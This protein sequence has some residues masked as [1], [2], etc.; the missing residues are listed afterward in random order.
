MKTWT[1]EMV[2]LLG[3]ESDTALAH[4]SDMSCMTVARR[5]HS[6]AIKPYDPKQGGFQRETLCRWS[7]ESLALLGHETDATGASQLGITRCSVYKTR[8]QMRLSPARRAPRVYFL[9]PE[10]VPL[11]GKLRG[12]E[13]A[14]QFGI[15]N[16]L[17]YRERK[18]RGIPKLKVEYPLSEALL[19]ELGTDS[20]QI[21]G[22]RHGAHY[23]KVR[24][25]RLKRQIVAYKR[26][27]HTKIIS[28]SSTTNGGHDR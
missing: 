25:L 1:D 3:A 20:D 16:D 14:N 12:A 5:Q 18:W 7:P 19:A 27:S 21:I 26:S 9:P 6:L 23:S 28:G 10:A 4:R 22:W 2:A 11:L 24:A 13:L 15:S 17:V 8:V